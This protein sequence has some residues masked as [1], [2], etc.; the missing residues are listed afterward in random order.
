[1]QIFNLKVIT[2]LVF[3]SYRPFFLESTIQ[4]LVYRVVTL[5]SVVHISSDR[6]PAQYAAVKPKYKEDHVGKQLKPFSAYC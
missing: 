2:D 6:S 3:E 4:N 5:A 1:M